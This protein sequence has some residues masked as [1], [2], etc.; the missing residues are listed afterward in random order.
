M[1]F[2]VKPDIRIK[3]LAIGLEFGQDEYPS[4]IINKCLEKGLLIANAS[5]TNIVMFP[6]LD[7]SIKVAKEGLDIFESCL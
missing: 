2:K 6:P 4:G 1:Q 7:I 5:G 3:G